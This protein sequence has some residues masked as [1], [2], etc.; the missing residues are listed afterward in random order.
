MSSAA[1]VKRDHDDVY[2]LRPACGASVGLS[3]TERPALPDS[4]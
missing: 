3:V 4:W 2:L 1:G